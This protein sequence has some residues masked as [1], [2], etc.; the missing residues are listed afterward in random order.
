MHGPG[1]GNG[2]VVFITGALESK[3]FL[4]D[5]ARKLGYK[6]AV[7]D[8]ADSGGEQLYKTGKVDMFIAI[9][10]ECSEEDAV[11]RCIS[12]I[13]STIIHVAGVVTFMEMAV[14]L[15]AHISHRMGLQ[16]LPP[17][18][19]VTARDKHL[20]RNS[21]ASSNPANS[22][23]SC[24][25]NSPQ[26]LVSAISHVGLPA[27]LKPIS[28]ADSIGV[29][30]VNSHEDAVKAFSEANRAMNSVVICSGLLCLPTDSEQKTKDTQLHTGP[31]IFL[32]EEY[33]DGPEVD[34]DLVMHSGRCVY[35]AVSDNGDTIEPYFTETY[36]VLP[37]RLEQDRQRALEELAIASALALGLH[38]GVFHVEAKLTSRGP[39]LIEVNARMGGGPICEMHKRVNNI[40]L[41]AEQIRVSC[42]IEPSY[43]NMNTARSSYAQKEFAY[44]TTNAITSGIVGP[45]L[46]FLNDIKNRYLEVI[47]LYCRVKPGDRI[48]GPEEGQPTWL[49]ELWIEQPTGMEGTY[50]IVERITRISD[51]IAHSFQINYV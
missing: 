12:S 49:V 28:G 45:R 21:L 16:G 50:D 36:G 39:R 10:L 5:T 32:L 8:A 14:T 20:T 29:K 23:R 40:D 30:R 44:M 19:A 33:L 24:V 51:E 37:S 3:T 48:V 27:V 38:S 15:T 4:F 7:I 41:A 17:L 46:S 9:D 11:S 31:P 25:V 34:V 18:A 2:Y 13:R 35:A 42:G 43:K 6:V 26:A 47:K 1:A 22:I